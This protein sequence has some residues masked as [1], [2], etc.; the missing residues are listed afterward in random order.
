MCDPFRAGAAGHPENRDQARPVRE[1]AVPENFKCRYGRAL[2]EAFA[3]A[4]IACGHSL[5]S[6]PTTL[7]P[8]P[9]ARKISNRLTTR[10]TTLPLMILLCPLA[11]HGTSAK[12]MCRA[13]ISMEVAQP[14]RSTSSSTKI[15]AACP[16]RKRLHRDG[17][18]LHHREQHRFCNY[19]Y[20]PRCTH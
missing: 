20:R 15:A 18:V 14:R 17:A 9:P 16:G 10:L 19:P 6:G 1:D 12:W 2:D 7:E 13:C 8:S 11:R 4:E 5:R 3:N